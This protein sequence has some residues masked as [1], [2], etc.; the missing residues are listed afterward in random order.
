[1]VF[2]QVNLPTKVQKYIM[3]VFFKMEKNINDTKRLCKN[4]HRKYFQ[5][6]KNII[7]IK[8]LC[9]NKHKKYFLN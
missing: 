2:F 9:K 8:R 4:K 3:K 6:W 5:N 1:M 7:D